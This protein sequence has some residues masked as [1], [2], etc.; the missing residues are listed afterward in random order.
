MTQVEN[1]NH[2]QASRHVVVVLGV[3]RS[4][5][6]LAMQALDTLG[7][8]TSENM[9][10]PNVSNPKGFFEDAD[11]VKIHK[12]LL[13]TLAPTPSMPLQ[14]GWLNTP[15]AKQALK[16]LKGIVETQLDAGQ[17]M[18]G[19][20]DP[21]TAT[22]LPLW[23]RLFNQLKVVPRFVMTVRQPEA[24]IESFAQQYGNDQ[25]FA[26]LIFL[27]RTLD[28]LYYTGGNCFLLPYENWFDKP[29][30][31]FQQLAD[32][33]FDKS[34]DISGNE[35]PVAPNLN[36]SQRAKVSIRNPMVRELY[37]YLHG[38]KMHPEKRKA[39][40]DCVLSQLEILASF[41]PWWAFTA[42][43]KQN[44]DRYSHE[45]NVAEQQLK[46][47]NACKRR[48]ARYETS[49]NEYKKAIKAFE[50]YITAMD[51]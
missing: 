50:T 2:N 14:E 10:P 40:M 22:F 44:S 18:W 36:R 37:G 45:L 42:S 21:R 49:L 34:T 31:T 39:L 1:S 24:I 28:A 11:I 23:N 12:H 25:E 17:G 51:N 32:F 4:G 48:L 38:C 33:V 5:T 20:K 6:S 7:V 19:F 27:L 35:P 47:F 16:Q 41:K 30:Q 13:N 26:E 29:E 15:E 8:H 43:Q 46:N 3:G 9:I